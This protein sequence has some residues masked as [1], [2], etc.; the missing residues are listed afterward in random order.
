MRI[1]TNFR[2][3]AMPVLVMAMTF[4]VHSGAAASNGE[5]NDSLPDCTSGLQKSTNYFRTTNDSLSKKQIGFKCQVVGRVWERTDKSGFGEA[6]KD[7]A[8]GIT[9]S[10][11]LGGATNS[12]SSENNLVTDS[13]AI[14]V[15]RAI[16]GEL[17]EIA[18]FVDAQGNY[19][20]WILP[21]LAKSQSPKYRDD[22]FVYWT[23][24]VF[25]KTAYIY[26]A[27]SGTSNL[28]LSARAS[29]RCIAR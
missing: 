4:C 10:E 14:N 2:F 29:V 12:G 18:D 15:C 28:D 5:S 9:W 19:G 7:Q 17:P 22:G 1:L 26:D 16:G 20:S 24:T 3:T 8:T 25:K 27:V 23:K 6:W 11:N 13:D 21:Q